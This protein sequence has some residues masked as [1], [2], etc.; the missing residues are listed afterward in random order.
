[1]DEDIIRLSDIKISSKSRKILPETDWEELTPTENEAKPERKLRSKNENI[2]EKPQNNIRTV[3][4]SAENVENPVENV[5]NLVENNKKEV[6]KDIIIANPEEIRRRRQAKQAPQNRDKTLDE[7]PIFR[8][9]KPKIEPTYDEP[10]ENQKTKDAVEKVFNINSSTSATEAAEIFRAEKK[11][12]LGIAVSEIILCILMLALAVI[13]AKTEKPYIYTSINFVLLLVSFAICG[14]TAIVPG[15]KSITSHKYSSARV[16][17][18]GY[19]VGF[20]QALLSIA[21]S[22]NTSGKMNIYSASSVFIAF[23]YILSRL[24]ICIKT[25]KETLVF[26]KNGNVNELTESVNMEFIRRIGRNL[27]GESNRVYYFSRV[28]FPGDFANRSYSDDPCGRF[29]FVVSL[30]SLLPALIVI[31]VNLCIKQTIFTAISAGCSV[32]LSA[33]P[34]SSIFSFAGIML[35]D[36]DLARRKKYGIA[37]FADAASAQNIRAII[38]DAKDFYSQDKISIEGIMDFSQYRKLP[39]DFVQIDQKK[40]LL[41]SAALS[42]KASSP[43]AAVFQA[44][45]ESGTRLPAVKEFTL[46]HNLGASGLIDGNFVLLGSRKMLQN[47]TVETLSVKDEEKMQGAGFEVLYL[48]V[49][50]KLTYAFALRYA[51]IKSMGKYVRNFANNGMKILCHSTDPFICSEMLSKKLDVNP[52]IIC[53]LPIEATQV[54][55][56]KI[57]RPVANPDGKIFY[58]KNTVNLFSVLVAARRLDGMRSGVKILSAI[59][60]FVAAILTCVLVCTVDFPAYAGVLVILATIVINTGIVTFAPFEVK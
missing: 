47:H 18:F 8:A 27:T 17:V 46:E 39:D 55:L 42:V 53:D 1:M 12:L 25:E 26:I 33:I 19:V 57:R 56:S 9:E 41:L 44:E 23:I 5:E 38:L 30:A 6:E 22:I 52:E 11:K 43:L 14:K 49:N 13:I 24:M 48:A 59:V 31:I 7:K 45:I 10:T 51:E 20:V 16:V 58:C 37:S 35:H 54:Y 50:G 36:S 2:G 40:A 34:V 32:I 3:Q 21:F 29:V 60:A 4:K 15:L 28:N